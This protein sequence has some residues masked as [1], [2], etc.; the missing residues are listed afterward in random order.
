[1]I[2]QSKIPPI[3]KPKSG[4]TDGDYVPRQSV[5]DK[6]AKVLV[7][8]ALNSGNGLKPGEVV[9]IA[10]PD[11]AKPLAKALHREV[12]LAQ[13]FPM[14]RLLPTGFDREFFTLASKAQLGFFP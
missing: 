7:N 13:G 5:I 4:L 3:R 2:N 6:Y 12:L 14:V 9:D 8:F 11:M 1:M 10:V